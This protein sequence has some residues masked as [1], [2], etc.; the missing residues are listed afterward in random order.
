MN[1]YELAESL[2][3][4]ASDV[5][6]GGK[7]LTDAAAM[8]RQQ[9]AEIEALKAQILAWENAEVPVEIMADIIVELEKRGF[10][11]KAQEK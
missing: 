6:G 10:I 5:Y 9:Q 4:W 7:T 1:L 8:L 11:E 3:L 2:E